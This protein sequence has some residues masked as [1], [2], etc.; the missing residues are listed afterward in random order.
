MLWRKD[1]LSTHPVSSWVRPKTKYD[2]AESQAELGNYFIVPASGT[3]CQYN[4]N[5]LHSVKVMT[6]TAT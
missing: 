3:T 1:L 2:I 4:R 5:G 6:S